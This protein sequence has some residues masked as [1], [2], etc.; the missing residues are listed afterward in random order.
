MFEA[1]YLWNGWVKKNRVNA[2]LIRLNLTLDTDIQMIL[3]S[4]LF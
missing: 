2:N 1:E 3:P 4:V